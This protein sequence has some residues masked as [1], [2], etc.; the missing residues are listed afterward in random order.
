MS[1]LMSAAVDTLNVVYVSV[2]VLQLFIFLLR[3][4]HS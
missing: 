2:S 3:T 1:V 4:Q